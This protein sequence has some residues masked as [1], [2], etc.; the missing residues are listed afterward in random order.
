[1]EQKLDVVIAMERVQQLALMSAKDK[2]NRIL[3]VLEIAVLIAVQIVFL[4]VLNVQELVLVDVI[5]DVLEVHIQLV[6][7]VEHSVLDIVKE[8]VLVLVPADVKILVLQVALQLAQ[9]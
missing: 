3:D 9:H 5:P 6:M 7:N 1:M 4:L 8:L 2:L